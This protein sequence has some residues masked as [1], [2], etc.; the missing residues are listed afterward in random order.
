M[1]INEG[2]I[3]SLQSKL[4]SQKVSDRE[5]YNKIYTSIKEKFLNNAKQLSNFIILTEE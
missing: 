4:T 2:D 1:I 3:D 5:Q